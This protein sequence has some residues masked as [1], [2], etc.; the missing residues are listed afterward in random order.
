MMLGPDTAANW[1]F[2]LG[3]YAAAAESPKT[4]RR[5][6]TRQ[7]SYAACESHDAVRNVRVY[8]TVEVGD[9]IID[10]TVRHP[11]V[12]RCQPGASNIDGY[13]ASEADDEKTATYPRAGG[14]ICTLLAAET[15]G[16]LSQTAE[17]VLLRLNTAAA[18]Y[19]RSRD[20]RDRHR[21]ARWRAQVDATLQRGVVAAILGSRFGDLGC[22]RHR[23]APLSHLA[24]LDCDLP[25]RVHLVAPAPAPT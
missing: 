16:R 7:Y 2:A 19:D 23:A 20:R 9:L 14:N 4:N 8:G 1:T 22:A 21:L 25:A 12:P 5:R 13:A 18:K 24:D 3:P 17:E 6:A 10:V 15:W 11:A